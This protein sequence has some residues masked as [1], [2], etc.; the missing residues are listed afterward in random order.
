M[1]IVYEGFIDL[2]NIVFGLVGIGVVGEIFILINV[3]D[4]LIFVI[5]VFNNFGVSC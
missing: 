4:C 1:F 3:G 2:G 5:N